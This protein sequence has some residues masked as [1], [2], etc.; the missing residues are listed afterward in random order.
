MQKKEKILYLIILILCFNGMFSW[1]KPDK[2]GVD[3]GIYQTE[4]DSLL[5]ELKTLDEKLQKNNNEIQSIKKYMV[6]KD[7]IIENADSDQ[8][9]SLFDDFFTRAR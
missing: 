2:T 1:F 3:Y 8:L 9:D 6:S 4:R 7:S 5:N